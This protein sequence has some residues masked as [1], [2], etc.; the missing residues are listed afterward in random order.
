M[1]IE[2]LA[3]RFQKSKGQPIELGSDSVW[4]MYQVQIAPGRHLLEIQRKSAKENPTQGLRLKLGSGE[5]LI[6]GQILSDVVLW[7]DNS[8][9][10]IEVAIQAKKATVL[11]I[12]N[13]WSVEGTM[14]AWIGNAG[15]LVE[16][17]D[18]HL[19]FRCSDGIGEVDFSDLIVSATFLAA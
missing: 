7:A 19:L 13:V 3:A 11:K 1:N 9:D 15:M 2:T 4:P 8:P 14:H 12:W 5:L 17:S 16:E 18:G 6:N 10:A